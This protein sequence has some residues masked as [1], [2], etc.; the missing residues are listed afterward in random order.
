MNRIHTNVINML[1]EDG[2]PNN[3]RAFEAGFE[4]IRPA[5]PASLLST[6]RIIELN[7]AGPS[8]MKGIMFIEVS[9]DGGEAFASTVVQVAKRAS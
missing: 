3:C 9:I 4:L 5:H 2:K 6:M 1:D 8:K 7:R